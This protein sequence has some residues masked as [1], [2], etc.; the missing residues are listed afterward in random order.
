MPE[1]L[2]GS[3]EMAP[4]MEFIERAFQDAR[5]GRPAQFR[6]ATA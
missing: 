5:E 4:S 6:S 3:V 2:T 1:H